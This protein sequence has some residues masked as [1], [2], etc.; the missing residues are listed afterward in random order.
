VSL[1]GRVFAVA[2]ALCLIARLAVAA[3]PTIDGAGGNATCTS[4]ASNAV[5]VTTSLTN[6]VVEIVVST[7]VSGT[8]GAPTV[9]GV[10]GASLTWASRKTADNRSAVCASSPA[11]SIHTELWWAF[12]S[13]TVTAQTVTA[14]FSGTAGSSIIGYFNVNGVFSSTNPFDTNSNLPSAATGVNGI[15]VGNLQTNQAHDLL[16]SINNIGTNAAFVPCTPSW[17]SWGTRIVKTAGSGA[18]AQ[19]MQA[20]TIGQSAT[21]SAATNKLGTSSGSC[22]TGTSN[23]NGWTQIFDALTGDSPGTFFIHQVPWLMGH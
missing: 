5:A 15:P 23:V 8:G 10:S 7:V 16:L 13:G 18:T 2:A 4:C 21:V 6:D 11:C 9:T 17:A 3:T 14:S 22:P 12:S 19:E 20:S 1:I